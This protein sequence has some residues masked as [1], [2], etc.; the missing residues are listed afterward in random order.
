MLT[1]PVHGSRDAFPVGQL[2]HPGWSPH[3]VGACDPP[4]ALTLPYKGLGRGDSHLLL[5]AGER[6]VGSP[7]ST[8]RVTSWI[9]RRC[10]YWWHNRP[11]VNEY[12]RKQGYWHK[13]SKEQFRGTGSPVW[14][15]DCGWNPDD[16]LTEVPMSVQKAFQKNIKGCQEL[17]QL[18]SRYPSTTGTVI[19]PPLTTKTQGLRITDFILINKQNHKWQPPCSDP[20]STSNF[21]LCSYHSPNCLG[22]EGTSTMT[23][24]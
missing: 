12:S 9:R 24:N 3:K 23:T 4:G 2:L 15:L 18:P 7:S 20:P 21:P 5:L 8:R 16:K 6:G 22:R 19:H 14:P 10:D 1:D 11:T 13:G 17:S